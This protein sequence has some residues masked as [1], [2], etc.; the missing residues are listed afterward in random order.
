[1]PLAK[2]ISYTCAAKYDPKAVMSCCWLVVVRVT[3]VSLTH[4]DLPARALP[5]PRNASLGVFPLRNLTGIG[6]SRSMNVHVRS[7]WRTFSTR[8]E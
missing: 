1:M 7:N 4:S 2:R 3:N 6:D 8:D 5:L